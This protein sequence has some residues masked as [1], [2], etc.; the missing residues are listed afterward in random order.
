MPD[1]RALPALKKLDELH[2]P[3]TLYEHAFARTM[4]DCEG[5]GDDIGAVHFK[6]LFLT[7]RAGT[8]FYL[9][10]LQADKKFHT[11]AVSRQLGSERLCFGSPEQLKE[12]LGLEPGSVTPLAL[13]NNPDHSV[14]VAIDRDIMAHPLLCMHPLVS[15]HTVAISRMD[16]IRYIKACGA[17]YKYIAVED[18]CPEE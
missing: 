5:I 16:L 15:N 12:K 6:N 7:N 2:I 14:R 17:D 18:A 10:L 3:Y 11:G 1:A 13:M 8:V 4:E 9:A